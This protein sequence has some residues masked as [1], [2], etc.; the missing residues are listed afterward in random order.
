M[1]TLKSRWT[2]SN[3]DF[4][5]CSCHCFSI[6]VRVYAIARPFVQQA[7]TSAP[8][9]SY[10][11]EASHVHQQRSVG[12]ISYRIHLYRIASRLALKPFGPRLRRF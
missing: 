9:T 4:L 1:T 2:D 5:L 7:V 6:R 8:C 12:K 3:L 11:D 10:G